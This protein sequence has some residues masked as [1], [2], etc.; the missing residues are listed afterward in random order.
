VLSKQG[1]RYEVEQVSELA[2][3]ALRPLDP[4]DPIAEQASKPT[5]AI[6]ETP[7][8]EEH[9]PAIWPLDTCCN[10]RKSALA[11]ALLSPH[12]YELPGAYIQRDVAQHNYLARTPPVALAYMLQSQ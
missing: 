12:R 1:Q 9:G 3:A 11:R 4:G 8:V 5:A 7:V 6:S 2:G 10:R